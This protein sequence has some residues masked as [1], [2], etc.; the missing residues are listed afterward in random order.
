MHQSWKCGIPDS[1]RENKSHRY[2]RIQR[3][4]TACGPGLCPVVAHDWHLFYMLNIYSVAAMSPCFKCYPLEWVFQ[5]RSLLSWQVLLQLSV[6]GQEKPHPGGT[7]L[8]NMDSSSTC[9]FTEDTVWQ[10]IWQGNILLKICPL[11]YTIKNDFITVITSSSV[12]P[13]LFHI[14]LW[15]T[16][17]RY[18]QEFFKWS[19]PSFIG[20]LNLFFYHA[21]NIMLTILIG[22]NG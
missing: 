13:S 6:K 12:T 14:A 7:L 10:S 21:T 8:C 15:L 11:Y 5:R 4:Q 17:H 22:Q 1:H 19:L 20:T 9:P 18:W 16:L 3:F 2:H